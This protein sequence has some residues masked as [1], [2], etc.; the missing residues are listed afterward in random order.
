MTGA[1]ATRT[2]RLP[3]PMPELTGSP[4]RVADV[5]NDL[6]AL[7][8]ILD[9]AATFA[10]GAGRCPSWQGAAGE[11]Y[12]RLV[13]RL[14][15]RADALSA[16]S[17]DI[18]GKVL[19]HA[20]V[21]A[22]LHRRHRD[23]DHRFSALVGRAADELTG[24][25]Q[26]ATGAAPAWR[27]A[28]PGADLLASLVD[29]YEAD[30]AR[31][32]A[33]LREAEETVAQA[34]ARAA[35]EAGREPNDDVPSPVRPPHVPDPETPPGRV[36]DWWSALTPSLRRTLLTVSP[37]LLGNLDGLP[38]AV[39]DRANRIRLA[40]DVAELEAIPTT[41]RTREEV[42]R[43][44][45][46]LAALRALRL[47]ARRAG[48]DPATGEPTPT[49]LY[50]YD[51]DSFDG[52]GRVA[53]AIGDLDHDRNLAVTVPGLGTDMGS[54]PDQAI[55]AV[56]LYEEANA[57][58][59]GT[60]TATM[61]W[62]GYDAPD[63]SADGTG[64]GDAAGV[65]DDGMAQDGGRRL[66]D[67]VDGLTGMRHDDP[68]VTV[69]GHS[70]GSTTAADGAALAPPGRIDDLVL[71]GSPGA[72]DGHDDAGDLGVDHG[73]VFVGRNSADP[74]TELGGHGGWDLDSLGDG[75]DHLGVHVPHGL[76][77]DPASDDFGA[78]RFQAESPT[79]EAAGLDGWRQ[80]H[81]GYFDP[82]SDS[83]ANMASI[84]DGD[85]DDVATA[86]GVHDPALP[87]PTTLPSAL[88]HLVHDADRLGQDAD[89]WLHGHPD[90]TDAADLVRTGKDALD[91]VVGGPHDPESD[92]AP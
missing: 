47:T 36:R 49:Q 29:D 9:D 35:S 42:L 67:L 90:W 38:A 51:P 37:E 53:V 33:D 18:G 71:V 24:T 7:S 69:V 50:V 83:L 60:T 20:E 4:T 81:L 85:Y 92:R 75:L 28:P 10:A 30:R 66:A 68:H 8:A 12:H 5:G 76:G 44:A 58:D 22:A 32:I 13:T 21:L 56:D 80:D 2:L 11:G 40:R 25:L 45:N 34:F 74:V 16:A 15:R 3:T 19:G 48:T 73:H 6:L 65:V 52:D 89:D 62:I 87:G 88:G 31:W 27:E 26:V 23:L 86:P 70:Y 54:A 57:H 72:G 46:A 61:F 64:D 55:K 14:R 39:R 84:V 41:E 82:G 78:T 1:L 77:T 43:L 91:G 17:R 59:P 79:R 63:G